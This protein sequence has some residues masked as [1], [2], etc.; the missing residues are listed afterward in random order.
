M[1]SLTIADGLGLIFD[2]DG[3]ILHSNPVHLQAWGRYLEAK[4]FPSDALQPE[5]MYG[6]RND[7]I[8]ST[9]FPLATREEIAEQ[10]NE[11]EI[12]YRELMGPQ[13][14][15]HLTLGLRDIL[16]ANRDRPI[17]LGT[18]AERANADFVLDL[19]G[20][21]PYFQTQVDGWMVENPKPSP[22]IYLRVAQDLGLAP[23]NCI[24]FEDSYSGVSA[25]LAAGAR[26]VGVTSTHEDFPQLDLHIA[27][28]T[29]LSLADWLSRQRPR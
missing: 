15:D 18:N 14:E 12:I 2:M 22:D 23:R 4:G 21:R 29:H 25:G 1:T 24:I 11:K 3:V 19:A 27:D 13:I 7:Q 26:V 10:S 9:L 8:L 6:K 16:E 20:I 5:K 28:F 17:G